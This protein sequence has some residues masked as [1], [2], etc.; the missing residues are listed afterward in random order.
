MGDQISQLS[1]HAEVRKIGDLTLYI[2]YE[3]TWNLVQVKCPTLGTKFCIKSLGNAPPIPVL[4]GVGLNIDRCIILKRERKIY[5]DLCPKNLSIIQ[6]S[7]PKFKLVA[8]LNYGKIMSACEHTYL[9]TYYTTYLPSCGIVEAAIGSSISKLRWLRA[10]CIL[11]ESQ[12]YKSVY[13]TN[14]FAWINFV[15]IIENK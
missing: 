4:G 5:R 9:E 14:L 7:M 8:G 1:P 11:P 10:Q 6:R 13:T 12:V 15:W 3:N 2:A